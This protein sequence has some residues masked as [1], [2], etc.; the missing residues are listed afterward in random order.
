MAGSE[1]PRYDQLADADLLRRFLEQRDEAAFA[2]IVRRH[3]GLVYGVC[4]RRLVSSH[5]AE[6]AF[7]ATFLVLAQKG[8]K[9]ASRE[10]LSSW[11]Y[12][13]AYRVALRLA[14][15]RAASPTAPLE[16]SL[17][18]HD[19]P[20]ELL[21]ARHEQIVTDEELAALP[22]R[23][24]A[25]VVLRYLAGKS[26]DEVAEELAISVSAVEGRLKR[27][28]AHLRGQ[29]VR[30]GIA[31]GT[32]L[33]TLGAAKWQAACAAE[34]L[35]AQ[36]IA[37]CLGGAS[38]AAGASGSATAAALTT[39]AAA[40][41]AKTSQ[42]ALQLANKEVLAMTTF[43]L[44]NVAAIAAIVLCTTT[45]GFGLRQALSQQSA[46]DPFGAPG[47]SGLVLD[48][49]VDAAG[50]EATGDPTDP[51]GVS[52]ESSGTSAG[53]DDL[54]VAEAAGGTTGTSGG[55][56]T[57]LTDAERAVLSSYYD[58][59]SSSKAEDQIRQALEEPTNLQYIDTPLDAMISDLSTRYNMH[60]EIDH[61][62]LQDVGID[63]STLINASYRDMTLRTALRLIIER[64][65]L[66]YIVEDEYLL[67]T[68]PDVADQRIDTRIYP[69]RPQWAVTTNDLMSAITTT[70]EPVTW[71]INGGPGSV[72]PLG[73]NLVISQTQECHDEIVELL[74]QLERA[75]EFRA[76]HG[77]PATSASGGSSAAGT[78][79]QRPG[80][81]RGDGSG[82][83][84]GLGGGRS[85]GLNQGGLGQGGLG[86][87]VAPAEER[88]ASSGDDAIDDGS[89][90]TGG[91]TTNNSEGST[92]GS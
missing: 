16:E 44:S 24:R 6:D 2:A 49:A 35:I 3:H 11:L 45:A 41:T 88:G 92:V 27:A 71:D 37:M 15:Q 36:T 72:T 77:Y 33:A 84:S 42:T 25:P 1:Q 51:F 78:A 5:D 53:A 86:T 29:L 68:T 55:G 12:G 32:T 82:F 17:M 60:I 40:T 66:T 76:E 28:K 79:S 58:M 57:G 8:H 73:N 81:H 48:Q 19:D 69:I 85:G 52:I 74:K 70:I 38:A 64:H 14:R 63:V 46:D 18:V 80:R 9:I 90:S 31:L 67:I 13:V 34:P 7:Q 87:G 61:R 75:A 21:A 89:A 59:S 50:G 39:K 83:G 54:F 56:A 62:A 4:R 23:L 22:E 91:S 43:K 65:E 47:G 20:L 10:S 26:N 30:R